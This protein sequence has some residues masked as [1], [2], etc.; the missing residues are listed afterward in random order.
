MYRETSDFVAVKRKVMSIFFKLSDSPFQWFFP[1]CCLLTLILSM[2]SVRLVSGISVRSWRTP[3]TDGEGERQ[4][5][6]LL[7]PP[8]PPPPPPPSQPHLARHAIFPP[9]KSVCEGG[10]PPPPPFCSFLS[11]S[12]AAMQNNLLLAHGTK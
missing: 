5:E 4:G 12:C 10:H 8:P 1:R 6:L 3:L 11:L 2:L 7:P 9:Q